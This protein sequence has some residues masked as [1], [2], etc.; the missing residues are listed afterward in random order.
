MTP[1]LLIKNAKII[2]GT[3]APWYK[4]DL[5]ITD[6]KITG[7]GEIK[8]KPE[9][10]IDAKGLVVSPGW[11]DVHNHADHTILGNPDAL[12]YT[13]QG[14]TTVTMGNCGLSMYPLSEQ[15][16]QDLIEYMKPFT[17]GLQFKY[18][19]TNLAEF[20]KR[21]ME[22]GTSINL[23]PFVG[24]GSIRIAT[25]GF[26]NRA[27]T[28]T[29]LEQMK[30]YLTEA[31]KQGSYGMS[32]GLGYPPGL[33]SD[34]SELIALGKVLQDYRGM[35][36]T[37]MR[38]E[39]GNLA[40]TIN[41]GRAMNVPVE[42]SHLGSSCGSRLNL[43]GRHEET[44]LKELDEARLEGIDITADIY[45]Y[46]AGSSLLS[47]VIPDWLHE[48][49][50]SRML[51]RIQEPQVQTQM[52]EEYTK[53]GRD[54][55]KIIVSYVKSEGNKDIEGM[56]IAAISEKW[57]KNIV[58]TV[59]KL[60]SDEKG[61]AMNITFWGTEEDVDTMIKH[62]A[63][64]PC[65]DGWILAPTGPLGAGKPHPRCYGAFPRYLDQYVKQKHLFVLE[66]AIRRMT[67]M[68]ATRLGLQDRG[69]IRIGMKADITVFDPETLKD[70][71]T[72]T[73]P[74]RYPE[75]ISYVIV[76]GEVTIENGEHTGKHNGEI[77]KQ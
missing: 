2:D 55:S 49:G 1:S 15:Y 22:K 16:R 11:I 14:V 41:L 69:L 12:S 54:F 43:R 61:E 7:I 66:E 20:N 36:S 50:V 74:R 71:A 9:Q 32:T 5:A 57:K 18:D 26:A 17:S 3:G 63:V 65:S 64:M 25:M 19:W 34:N 37:H 73:D 67:A 40:D 4:A 51:E 48:G 62:P 39:D 24:H 45:P 35:Y 58:D 77:I 75:G 47:Q 76:N 52:A 70:N 46:I 33:Y 29:E 42:V 72:F 23:V 59:C 53:F 6:D 10:V 28:D 60:M 21:V 38:G 27:P 13:H 68:P 8:E 44:T 56:S 31:M 30:Q